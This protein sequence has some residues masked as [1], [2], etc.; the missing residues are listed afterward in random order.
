MT[1]PARARL[2]LVAL[3]AGL[4]ASRDPGAA[5]PASPAPAAAPTPTPSPTPARAAGPDG[6]AAAQSFY[7]DRFSRR[8]TVPEMTELG[9]RLFFDASLSASGKM[10]CATCHDPH[11]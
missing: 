7:A 3:A 8:A 5:P 11:F 9:R 2:A 6:S 1:R 4:G 10:S